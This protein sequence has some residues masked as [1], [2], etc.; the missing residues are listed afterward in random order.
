M[1]AGRNRDFG[2]VLIVLAVI[3]LGVFLT[4]DLSRPDSI[5]R[6][7]FGPPAPQRSQA[8]E[9]IDAVRRSR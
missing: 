5:V 4:F 8:R 1:S 2:R 3:L 9:L 6:S 7:W